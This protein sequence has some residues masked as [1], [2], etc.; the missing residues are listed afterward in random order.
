MVSPAD[1]PAEV[2]QDK[3][4]ASLKISGEAITTINTDARDQRKKDT[5]RYAKLIKKHV[6]KYNSHFKVVVT[7]TTISIGEETCG[8]THNAGVF[9]YKAGTLKAVYC[10]LAVCNYNMIA[11][12]KHLE[13]NKFSPFPEDEYPTRIRTPP[14]GEEVKEEF[15][16]VEG[17][18]V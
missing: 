18:W 7:N 6:E 10:V 16:L 5:K 8:T 9:Q 13:E 1:T 14:P 4:E 12:S 3:R 15:K 11:F 17:K 2:A